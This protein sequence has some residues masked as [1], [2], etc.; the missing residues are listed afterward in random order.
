MKV[1][2]SQQLGVYCGKKPFLTS[3]QNSQIFGI[4]SMKRCSVFPC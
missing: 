3:V 1:A 4:L 2:V